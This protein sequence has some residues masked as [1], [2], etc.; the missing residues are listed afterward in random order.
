MTGLGERGVEYGGPV[1]AATIAS[2]EDSGT[3]RNL[4]ESDT[5][6]AAAG[7]P[8]VVILLA[9]GIVLSRPAAGAV[10]AAASFSVGFGAFKRVHG[11]PMLAMVLAGLG[12]VCS[13]FIG[14]VAGQSVP[15]ILAVAA[16]W[17]FMAAL[18]PTITQDIGWVGQQCT[19]FLLVAGAFPGGFGRA[20]DRAMLV[21]CG[22]ALQFISM[23]LVLRL[24]KRIPVRFN[25]L[26][27]SVR[28][29][30]AALVGEVLS[31][32]PTFSRAV[33]L[34]LVLTLAVELWRRFDLQNGYWLGMT[35]LLL[36]KPSPGSTFWRATERIG[37]TVIG[38]AAATLITH[39]LPSPTPLW[40]MAAITGLLAGVTWS[41]QQG[42]RLAG[43]VLDYPGSYAVFAAFLTAY[44]VFL[45]DYGGLSPRGVATQRILLTAAGGLLAFLVHIPIEASWLWAFNRGKK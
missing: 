41:L 26:R 37:G 7:I 10:A 12:L 15:G 2:Q 44:V 8:A 16:V 14:T 35:V 11:S 6:T 42:N 31:A 45:L 1:I 23:G 4:L 20:A 30:A 40:T 21:F 34:A 5:L 36:V 19:I 27:E 13:A 43:M 28:E 18:L 17:G 39:S 3:R 9:L 29:A 38:A 32:S 25:G 24:F 33:R 22:A